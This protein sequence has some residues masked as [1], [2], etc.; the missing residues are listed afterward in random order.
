MRPHI[1]IPFGAFAMGAGAVQAQSINILMEAVPDT[2]Y[3]QEL[4]PEF[5][6]ATGID[7]NL[8]VVNYAEMHTKLVPQLVS[9]SGSYSAIVVDFYWVGEFYRAGWMQPLDDRIEADG[10]DTSVYVPA[11][12]DLV[13][14]VEGTTYMLPFYNYAMGLLYRTDLLEDEAN[15]TAWKEEHGSELRP[16]ETWD[17]YRDQ[18]AFFT[19]DGIYGVVNQ[20]LRPDPIAMEWSNYLF[21]HGGTFMDETWHATFNSDEGVAALKA[22]IANIDQYGP[23]GAASFSFDEAFNVF[24]QGQ[25]YSYITYNF[26]RAAVD[27]P[28]QSSVA[29]AAEIMGVPGPTPGEGGSLNGAWGWAIP[30]SSP[31]P[32]AAWEF[33]KWV[34]SPEIAKRRA[35]MGGSP[36]R[37]DV[38][39][40]AEVI[41]EY[42]QTEAL[43][44]LLLG[45]HNFPT[46]TYTPQFVEVLGRELSLA[47]AGEKSAREAL[48]AAAEEFDALAERDGRRG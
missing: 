32:D 8:E 40:D 45:A 26:F 33:L 11:M 20:G 23:V 9:N 1:L 7:V 17:E 34:E 25:A 24:S 38:F 46:F 18:V 37:L 44:E 31:D 4:L 13:G 5:E 12:M 3:V 30:R 10:F 27:D 48:D 29:G 21:A 22:Y 36:T 16:P 2:T 14:E 43:K 19:K 15:R 47:V 41:A 42:P 39:D 35:L 6:E 28:S